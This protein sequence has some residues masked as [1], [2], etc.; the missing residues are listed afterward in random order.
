MLFLSLGKNTNKVTGDKCEV[1]N[2]EKNNQLFFT[3]RGTKKRPL[4][5]RRRF[6]V[7]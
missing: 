3:V 6:S 7:I 2:E 4:F 1:M 5:G